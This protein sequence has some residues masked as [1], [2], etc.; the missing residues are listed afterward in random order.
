MAWENVVKGL[1]PLQNVGVIS[2]QD[3]LGMPQVLADMLPRETLLW[4]LQL[5]KSASAS[6]NSHL[7]AVKVQALILCR[8]SLIISAIHC[9]YISLIF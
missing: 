5:L 4:K 3:L 9:Y 7:H 1:L 8:S 2:S 6:A